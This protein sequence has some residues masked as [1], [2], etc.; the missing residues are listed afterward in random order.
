[1][2]QQQHI[3]SPVIA[4]DQF[5]PEPPPKRRTPAEKARILANL[6]LNLVALNNEEGRANGNA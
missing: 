3:D 6:V 4:L 1:M 2:P 5:A